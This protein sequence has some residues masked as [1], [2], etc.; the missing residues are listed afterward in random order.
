MP[1]HD[2]SVTRYYDFV[3][4]AMRSEQG[5]IT[6]VMVVATDVTERVRAQQEAE[7]QWQQVE[8]LLEQAPVAVSVYRGANHVIE[9]TNATACQ[10]MGRTREEALNTPLFELLPEFA[11]QGL[12]ELM[13]QVMTTGKPYVAHAFPT[14]INRYGRH[15]TAYWDF[16]YY[17]YRNAR[18]EIIGVTVM[19][20]EVTEQVHARQRVESERRQLL[21]LFEQFPMGM[22]MYRGAEHTTE[23]VNSLAGEL[24]GVDEKSLLGQPLFEMLPELRTQGLA[25][26]LDEVF[27]TGNP[28]ASDEHP[29]AFDRE[30]KSG[31]SYFNFLYHPWRDE[32]DRIVGVI[33][34]AVD[35]SQRVA[36]RQEEYRLKALLDNSTSFIGLADATGQ[37][38][39]LNPAGR[40]LIGMS[41]ETPIS[42]YNILDFFAED[43]QSLVR[44]TML[45]ALLDKGQGK[46]MGE[47]QLRPLHSNQP[48]PVLYRCFAVRDPITDQLL[49]LG[50]ITVDITEQ[51][52]REEVVR[53]YQEQ[54]A[55][56]N[57]KMAA[58][59]QNLNAS[60]EELTA[61]NG[62]L[63]RVN[64]DLD[65]FVYSASHDLKAPITNIQGLITLLEQRLSP[66][67]QASDHIQK[68]FY[69]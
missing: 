46:W 60:N 30:G 69:R 48:I 44:D 53:H 42:A 20:S 18:H 54:L 52:Q 2:D 33:S 12:E 31:L 61:A 23:L 17:P 63:S 36:A 32:H 24:W 28:F 55:L 19:G 16:I 66:G 3:C 65:N 6:G 59:N 21:N 10:L 27:R 68:K 11:T 26:R 15:D 7:Q 51:K 49:G 9:M 35:V 25:D 67:D 40:E 62:R 8:G 43:D 45:P 58:T 34:I 39:Y 50:A 13:N 41:A 29:V 4:D 1:S 64:A 57:R 22:A 14:E 38:V 47:Y 5:E 37:G 56:T